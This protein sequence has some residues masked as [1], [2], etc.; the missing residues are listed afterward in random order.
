MLLITYKVND[1]L[2]NHIAVG[3]TAAQFCVY[4]NISYKESILDYL[5]PEQIYC[6]TELQRA[7]TVFLRTG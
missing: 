6:I 3:M 4:H 7:N 5:I 1:D 2:I